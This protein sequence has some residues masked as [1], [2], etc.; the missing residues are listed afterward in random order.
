MVTIDGYEDVP[1]DDGAAL[2]KAIAHQ[3]VAVAICASMSLQLY[4]SGVV[5]DDACCQEL[6]HGVLAVGYDDGKAD[7]L[8][9]HYII[10][11]RAEGAGCTRTP[12]DL[13][14]PGPGP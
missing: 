3:P 7:G 13:L 2:K 1:K 10:K 4:S 6:N 12:C 14:H 8:E 9:P 11:V 5:G